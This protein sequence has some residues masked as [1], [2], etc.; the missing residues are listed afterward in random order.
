MVS[1][2]EGGNFICG[3]FVT[4]LTK[5]DVPAS[6]GQAPPLTAEVSITFSLDSTGT[7]GVALVPQTSAEHVRT[8][9]GNV[10]PAVLPSSNPAAVLSSTALT[11]TGA[12]YTNGST[13]TLVVRIGNLAAN[14]STVLR[15]DARIECESATRPTGNLQAILDS[16]A[17]TA[18][19]TEKIPVGNQ[20]LSLQRVG[21]ILPAAAPSLTLVKS[22]SSGTAAIIGDVIRYSI[23]ATNTG[24]VSLHGVTVQDTGAENLSCDTILPALMPAPSSITCSA[25]HTVTQHEEL[26]SYG[27]GN[28]PSRR[29][30]G[31][32]L[33]SRPE[34]T[35]FLK[36]ILGAQYSA[37]NGIK[38]RTVVP[39]SE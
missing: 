3:D 20:T 37:W 1:S 9:A 8:L 5:I 19:T 12:T 17:V 33:A 26:E 34:M 18:P 39:D 11:P 16:V 27:L 7:S 25:T 28:G 32:G 24:N 2:L 29:R 4:Y 13:Q 22:Q 30:Q 23:V 36:P 14:S 6:P 21:N 15:T 38:F 10:D 31:S 35:E